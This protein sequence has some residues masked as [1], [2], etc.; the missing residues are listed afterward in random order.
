MNV[1]KAIKELRIKQGLSQS[2]L[3]SASTVT[4]SALSRIEQGK[5]RPGTITLN[6]ISKALKVPVSLVY[7]L[8]MEQ[9][10][11]PKDKRIIYEKLFPV[12]QSM[13]LEMGS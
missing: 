10:D 9:G 4:Q 7:A 12:L 11:V 1:G 5:K 13:I 6:K 2:E 3:A 8:G